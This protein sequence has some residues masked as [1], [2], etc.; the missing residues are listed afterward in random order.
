M[1]GTR[2]LAR[3]VFAKRRNSRG[4]GG[5]STSHGHV[6]VVSGKNSDRVESDEAT[7]VWKPLF[8]RFDFLVWVVAWR[9][10]PSRLQ[11]I[12]AGLFTT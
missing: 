7:V 6:P 10:V 9:Q 12:E 2:D 11:Q 8:S 3:T 5:F 1:R 4:Q